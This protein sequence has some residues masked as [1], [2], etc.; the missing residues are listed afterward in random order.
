M[1][2]PIETAER[3]FELRSQFTELLTGL[4]TSKRHLQP[5]IHFAMKHYHSA[6]DELFD[7][8]VEDLTDM[9]APSMALKNLLICLESLCSSALQNGW[10]G[11]VDLTA[12][13]LPRI[14]GCVLHPKRHLDYH[15]SYCLRLLKLI[16]DRDWFSAEVRCT[17]SDAIERYE[18]DPPTAKDWDKLSD[19]AELTERMEEEREIQKKLREFLWWQRPGASPY[20]EVDAMFAEALPLDL[21]REAGRLKPLL[22]LYLEIRSASE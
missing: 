9:K 12:K 2:P 7:V 3:L 20:A 15:V 4:A 17:L 1:S 22:D 8:L 13:A 21:E 5:A 6:R 18:A 11:Y 16:R 14:T 19:K 10:G